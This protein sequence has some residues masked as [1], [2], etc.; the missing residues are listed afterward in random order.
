LTPH[1]KARRY[2]ILGSEC[3]K[4]QIT[5]TETKQKIGAPNNTW[6]EFRLFCDIMVTLYNTDNT[7]FDFNRYMPLK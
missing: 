7:D 4:W 6:K 3:P 5:I 2:E 1:S